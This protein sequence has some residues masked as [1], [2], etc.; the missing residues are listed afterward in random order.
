MYLLIVVSIFGAVYNI[1]Y[2][3][4]RHSDDD[5]NMNMVAIIVIMNNLK[6]SDRNILPFVVPNIAK[7]GP[8]LLSLI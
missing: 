2:L 3:A 6:I 1:S 4:L 8:L 7:P 5:V